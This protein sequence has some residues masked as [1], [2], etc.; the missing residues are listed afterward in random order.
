MYLSLYMSTSPPHHVLIY[1]LFLN[2]ELPIANKRLGLVWRWGGW[3]STLLTG[4]LIIYEYYVNF[5]FIFVENEYY[6]NY[7]R[8]K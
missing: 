5:Y 4:K 1:S 3:G 7:N 8:K 2:F 6:V